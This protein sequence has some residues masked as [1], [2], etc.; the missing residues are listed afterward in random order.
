MFK[1]MLA[2]LT[3]LV[4]LVTI[5]GVSLAET[6]ETAKTAGMTLEE[7]E[8]LNGEPVTVHRD[9]GRVTFIGGSCSAEPVKSYEDAERMIRKG[10]D[11]IDSDRGNGFFDLFRTHPLLTSGSSFSHARNSSRGIRMRFPIRFDGNPLLWL[12]L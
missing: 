10:L 6:A 4:M 3:A 1:R 9:Q 11:L 8:T 5:A 7:I 2:I 12:K